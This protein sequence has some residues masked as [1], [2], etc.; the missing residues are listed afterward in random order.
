MET[1]SSEL[2]SHNENKLYF[3]GLQKSVRDRIDHEVFF[4][5]LNYI[6][7]SGTSHKLIAK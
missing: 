7:V 4:K 3:C 1:N 6:G 5:K 2:E